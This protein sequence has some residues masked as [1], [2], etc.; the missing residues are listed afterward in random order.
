[1]Q[2]ELITIFTKLGKIGFNQLYSPSQSF[3][4]FEFWPEMRNKE[5]KMLLKG[6]NA[7]LAEFIIHKGFITSITLILKMTNLY[8]AIPTFSLI[9]I[10]LN[11][12]KALV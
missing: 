12:G 6:Q 8:Q 1:M 5:A 4:C 2:P 7:V 11:L 9:L 10:P 3:F